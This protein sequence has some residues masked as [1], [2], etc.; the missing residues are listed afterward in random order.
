M[1]SNYFLPLVESRLL[2]YYQSLYVK[3]DKLCRDKEFVYIAQ[4]QG[5][6]QEYSIKNIKGQPGGY[7]ELGLVMNTLFT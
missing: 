2:W 4:P 5:G 3:M 7:L 1:Y 6:T